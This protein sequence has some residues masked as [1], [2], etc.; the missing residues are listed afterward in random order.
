M[1]RQ[2]VKVMISNIVEDE[3]SEDF[4]FD[5]VCGG[6]KGVDAIYWLYSLVHGPSRPTFDDKLPRIPLVGADEM[7]GVRLRLNQA[8][9][10]KNGV[11]PR[12]GRPASSRTISQ[13]RWSL[14]AH[15]SPFVQTFATSLCMRGGHGQISSST[16]FLALQ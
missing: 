16:C 2:R 13:Y 8:D 12:R 15:H 5:N 6:I 14:I 3:V 1:L 7:Q 4:C 11:V 10:Q 9:S